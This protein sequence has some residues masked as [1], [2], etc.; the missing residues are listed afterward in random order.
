MRKGIAFAGNMI[1]DTI[2]YIQRYPAE[3]T[4]TTVTGTARAS[5]GAACNCAVDIARL[6]PDVPV[7]LVGVVGEDAAGDFLLDAM[8]ACPQIDV[9]HVARAGLTSTTDVMTDA[10]GGRTFFHY[11]GSNALLTRAHF[12]MARLAARASML[13]VGYVLLLDGLD[14]EDAE[15]GT[16][17]ARVLADARA[18]GLR[19][20]VDVVS[21]DSDRYAR[22]V[23]PA[24]RYADICVMN[25][26][27][28]E[29]TT[30]V[31]LRDETGLLRDR[32]PEACR[33][34]LAMGVG[35]WAVVH[36]A[37]AACGVSRAGEVVK[38]AS[39]RVPDGFIVSSVGAGD[40]FAA[41][42]VY[43]AHQGWGLARAVEVA[44]AVAAWSLSGAGACDAMRPLAEIL[45]AMEAFAEPG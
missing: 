6:D 4:L 42:I 40:A 32:M 22:L 11:R 14:A 25:E 23:P 16:V 8:R 26:I 13:H 45:R 10:A 34:L 18:A 43:A 27:E 33:A 38:R 17:M 1:V 5:G 15:Y 28:A 20:S 24:L 44:G 9:S 12:D 3:H 19:T 29:R 21:E 7:T 30:G 39:W 41:G 2:K 31:R 36:A 35:E 37:E